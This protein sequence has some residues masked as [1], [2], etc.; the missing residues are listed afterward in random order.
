[1]NP[2]SFPGETRTLSKPGD[3]ADEECSP[4]PVFAGVLPGDRWPSLVSCWVP[5][6]EE[7]ADISAGG[8]VWLGIIG[9]RHPPVWLST[10]KPQGIGDQPAGQPV[11]G[12]LPTVPP[13]GRQPC[14]DPTAN[15]ENPGTGEG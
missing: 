7:R 8:P 3:M 12:T 6:E 15:P 9:V 14:G 13:D 2:T 10:V 1:M 11:P 5:T 4:L